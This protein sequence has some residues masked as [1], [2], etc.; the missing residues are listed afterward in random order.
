MTTID[1][2]AG[3]QSSGSV[4]GSGRL[5]ASLLAVADWLTSSDHKKIG[6]L[7]V[8]LA[9][10]GVL[11]SLA[12]SVLLGFERINADS[13]QVF[14]DDNIGQFFTFFRV[15][16]VF[17]AVLPMLVGMAVA[18]APIQVGARSI[19]FARGA[20]L[21]LW[22]W[23]AGIVMVE[24]SYL[25]NGGPG[26]GNETMVDLFLLGMLVLLVGLLFAS[27]SVIVT[28]LS[29]RAPGMSL[30]RAPIFA[31]GALVGCSALV[32]TLPALAGNLIYTFVDHRNGRVAFGGN[33]GVIDWIGWALGQPQTYVFV[34]IAFAVLGDVIAVASGSRLALR[35][36][37]LAGIGIVATAVLG[38][39]IQQP[40]TMEWT[41]GAGDK[42]RDL[43]P[44]AIFNVLPIVGALAVLGFAMFTLIS[45]NPRLV[46]PFAPALLGVGSI[47]IGMVGHALSTISRTNLAPT[48]FEEAE[49]IFV[50]YGGLMAVMAAVSFWGPKLWG[51]KLPASAVMGTGVLAFL[52]TFLAGL[53]YFVAGFA[54]Q[55]GSVANGFSYDGPQD[56]WN[57][58][59]TA[60]HLL[61]L[62]A[63]LGFVAAALVGFRSGESAGDDPWDGQTL[64]WSTS[65]PAPADNFAEVPVVKSAEPLLD[66]KSGGAA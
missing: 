13:F 30:D 52:G 26:G 16:L 10:G 3:V 7:F 55:P 24:I 2:H 12:I 11:L 15:E 57:L 8:G 36:V 14:A 4:A 66:L 44:W 25:G 17:G 32:F 40:Q 54:D 21:G 56:A 58:I 34:I 42:L 22:M 45:N 51:R 41:G 46:P 50:M 63:V 18:V 65:S 29:A 9:S 27:V 47:L 1:T 23:L 38:G 64:E 61:V 37:V 19:S 28:V 53:P 33:K 6:R 62:V 31:W 35:G 49:F 59:S 48:V 60:G 39:I 43:A 5:A 20:A